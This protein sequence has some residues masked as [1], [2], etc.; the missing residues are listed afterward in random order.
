MRLKSTHLNRWRYGNFT[1]GKFVFTGAYKEQL[2]STTSYTYTV[3]FHKVYIYVLFYKQFISPFSGAYHARLFLVETP[4]WY[5]FES[6]RENEEDRVQ[7]LKYVNL[8]LWTNFLKLCKRWLFTES[9]PN[10]SGWLVPWSVEVQTSLHSKRFRWFHRAQ[11]SQIW[12]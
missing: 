12:P 4:T 10:I 9:S 1:I 7:P 3:L 6:P 11:R 2:T 8:V 5:E